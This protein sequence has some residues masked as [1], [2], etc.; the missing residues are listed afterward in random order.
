MAKQIK[1]AASFI[2]SHI[3]EAI[4]LLNRANALD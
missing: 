1:S 3:I 2:K 4:E